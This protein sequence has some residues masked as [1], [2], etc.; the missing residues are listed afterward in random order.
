M[1]FAWVEQITRAGLNDR[2]QSMLREQRFGFA[3]LAMEVFAVR[4]EACE[5]E[6]DGDA[7]VAQIREQLDRRRQAVL[8]ESVGVVANP[9]KVVHVIAAQRAMSSVGMSNRRT[10]SPAVQ[11][12]AA[13]AAM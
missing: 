10:A 4:I 8:R 2:S 13:V 5:V 3:E 6:R 9:H 12:A 7:L 1:L 11:P